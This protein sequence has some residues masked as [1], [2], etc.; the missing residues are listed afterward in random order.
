[1]SFDYI[2]IGGGISG[3]TCASYL[4]KKNKVLLI[5]ETSVL[6]GC[7]S[8]AYFDDFMSEHSP[9]VYSSCYKNFL[10]LIKTEIDIDSDFF[11]KYR[12]QLSDFSFF[13]NYPKE[14]IWLIIFYFINILFP[15][16]KPV[17]YYTK[18][19]DKSLLKKINL[20]CK[21]TDGISIDRYPFTQ[22][23]NL[24]NHNFLGT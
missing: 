5:E 12:Y 10:N 18:S 22:F 9:R 1:M 4:C 15:L 3:L 13:L 11:I 16:K 23:L 2:I 20:I 21:L 8:T 6:G 19:F 14:L 24:P 7:H 17:N